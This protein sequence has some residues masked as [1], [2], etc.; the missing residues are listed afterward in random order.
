M[1][2]QGRQH[3]FIKDNWPKMKTVCSDLSPFYLEAA[4]ENEAREEHG[5]SHF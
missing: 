5:H 2:K 4:R 3:T 1:W